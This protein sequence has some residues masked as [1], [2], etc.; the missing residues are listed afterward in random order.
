MLAQ[1]VDISLIYSLL[2]SVSALL[3]LGYIIL[4]TL[5]VVCLYY[6][7]NDY[8]QQYNDVTQTQVHN[9]NKGRRWK[10]TVAKMCQFY[11]Q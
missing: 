10:V 11:R 5:L 7:M 2:C 9:K 1:H 6:A 8:Q 3:N 4:V